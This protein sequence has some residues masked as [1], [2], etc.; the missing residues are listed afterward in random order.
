MSSHDHDPDHVALDRTSNLALSVRQPWAE[1]IL[2]S[3]KSIEIRTWTTEYRGVLWLHTGQKR[4]PE[5]EAY[6]GLS[7]LFYGG[8]VGQVTISS[9]VRMDSERWERWRTR[10]LVPGSMP[11][12]SFGWLLR[13]P[14]RLLETVDARGELGLFQLDSE[15]AASLQRAIVAPQSQR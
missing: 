15:K 14:V 1:L 9:V 7:N 12:E 6:F 4:D 13:D 2:S 10:H 8:F 3:R 5:A 11:P